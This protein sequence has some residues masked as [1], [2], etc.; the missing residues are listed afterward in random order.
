MRGELPPLIRYLLDCLLGLLA[1]Q[2]SLSQNQL[3]LFR[4]GLF[5]SDSTMIF[6]YEI[7]YAV[8]V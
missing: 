3:N 7:V 8:P 6:T 2:L 4:L 5:R 1:D